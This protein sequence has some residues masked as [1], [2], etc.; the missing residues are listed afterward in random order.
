MT[1]CAY[2]CIIIREFVA[3]IDFH[4]QV[5]ENTVLFNARSKKSNINSGMLQASRRSIIEAFTFLGCYALLDDKW[6]PK[7]RHRLCVPAA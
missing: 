7:F 3:R 6:Q 4:A 5:Y 1:G 2:I